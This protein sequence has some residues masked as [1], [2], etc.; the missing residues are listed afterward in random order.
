MSW[1]DKILPTI[2]TS[3]SGDKKGVKEGVWDKCLTVAQ[4]YISQI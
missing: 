3:I 1:L 2:K 4:H